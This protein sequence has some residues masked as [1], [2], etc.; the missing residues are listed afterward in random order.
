M[1]FTSDLHTF[2]YVSF[3]ACFVK[4]LFLFHAN[5]RFQLQLQPFLS[6]CP[7]V[8]HCGYT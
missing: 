3:I 5:A 8:H 7:P 4:F 2:G 1:I 6:L